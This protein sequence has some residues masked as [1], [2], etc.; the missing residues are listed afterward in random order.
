MVHMGHSGLLMGAM[1][2]ERNGELNRGIDRGV[3]VAQHGLDP[4]F[5]IGLDET[6]VLAPTRFGVEGLSPTS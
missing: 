1:V 2:T 4:K 6:I 5:K 3:G